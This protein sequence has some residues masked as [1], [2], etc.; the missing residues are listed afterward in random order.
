MY[1][2]EKNIHAWSDCL[3][4]QGHFKETDIIEL[5]SHLH[6]EIEDLIHAGLS[7]EEAFLIS[8]KRFGDTHSVSRE[9]SKVNTEN[10]WK[11]L[12][13]EPEPTGFSSENKRTI[14]LVIL[15]SF[16]A[17]TFF[18]I[19]ELFGYSFNDPQY[20]LFY[21]KNLS[22]F[23]LPLI[24]LFFLYKNKANLKMTAVILGIFAGA[25]LLINAYPSYPPNSTE[26]LTALHLP[27]FLWLVTGVAYLGIQWRSSQGRMN[28]IRFTGE[29]IIYG[30]LIFCGLIVLAMFTQAMF[31]AIQ[32][33][34]SWFIQ[35]YLIVYGAAAVAMITVYLVETKKSVV[36][37]FA[38]I[39]AKIFSPLFL[40]IML[41]FLLVLVVSG[42]SPFMERD[43][44]IAF[45]FMLVLVLGLVLYTISARNPYAK[46]K[47]FDYLNLALIVVAMI[48]DAVALSAILLRLSAFGITP[49]KLAALGENL[50]L[51]INLAGLA[52]LY[53]RFFAKKID[54]T[55][56]ENWQTSYLYAYAIWLAIVAFIFPIVFGFN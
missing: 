17:G 56:I 16:L 28:F 39:L 22:F 6:D 40:F 10:L 49:N 32:I 5:E 53:G 3:R 13:L 19:P 14:G 20:Q 4:S 41:A 23:I 38:P 12:M 45:D 55:Q 11:Q 29:A 18:K 47:L 30:T 33:D 54:F 52:W 1:D 48:I 37:N 24:A 44:L 9:Y 15:F 51:L 26:L 2:L 8:V 50:I 35:N 31:F 21:F 46:N 42:K 43:Y 7:A 36:E 34:A 27:L 25:A